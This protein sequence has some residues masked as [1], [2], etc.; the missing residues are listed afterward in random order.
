MKIL[1]AFIKYASF[2]VLF[3]AV[4]LLSSMAI[5]AQTK[6]QANSEKEFSVP[7]AKALR[8]GLSAVEKIHSREMERLTKGNS[9]S[10]TELLENQNA[11]KNY[12]ACRRADT[13]A[14]LKKLTADERRQINLKAET[15]LKIARMRVDLIAYISFDDNYDEPVNYTITQKAITLVEDYKGILANIYGRTR[16]TNALGNT[17]AATRDEKQ[18]GAL[19]KRIEKIAREYDE[20]AEFAAFKTAVEKNLAEIKDDIGTEKVITTAFLVR[21][22]QMNLANEN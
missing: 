19:L 7:C 11:A 9:D 21:L 1:I 12:L 5:G 6:P 17:T 2:S 13:A 4:A 20:G 15:A 8:I 22:L 10:D 18:I 14:K 16:D 3:L